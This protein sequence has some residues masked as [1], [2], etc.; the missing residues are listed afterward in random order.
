MF[1][2]DGPYLMP[3]WALISGGRGDV[4][5]GFV[6]WENNNVWVELRLYL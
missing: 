2:M 4:G 6:R 5:R 1:R 3:G